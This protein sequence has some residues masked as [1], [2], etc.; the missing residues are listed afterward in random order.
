MHIFIANCF[1]VTTE[2]NI[3]DIGVV[4]VIY[5]YGF[6]TPIYYQIKSWKIGLSR[7]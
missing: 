7:C 6:P 5:V 3:T 4:Y 1:V 2:T